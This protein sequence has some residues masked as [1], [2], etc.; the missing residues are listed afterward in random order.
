MPELDLK[1]KD[2]H[3]N[4]FPNMQGYYDSK[5]LNVLH[6]KYLARILQGKLVG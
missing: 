6:A 2:E 3:G 1:P 5:L 4:L